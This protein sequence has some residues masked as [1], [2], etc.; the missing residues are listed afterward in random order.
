MRMTDAV[1]HLLIINVL[2]FIASLQYG[3]LLREYLALWFVE[4]PNF[5]YWQPVSSMFMHGSWMHLLFNMYGLWAFGSLLEQRWGSSKFLFFYFSC[6]LGAAALYLGVNYWQYTSGIETLEAAGLNMDTVMDYIMARQPLQAWLPYL[7]E[8]QIWQMVDSFT[9]PALG[10]S[11]AIYGILVAFAFMFSEAR[12]M[13]IFLPVPIKAKYFV[14]LIIAGD[15]FFGITNMR[16]GIAHFAH[17]GGAL[18]GFIM[19]WYWKKNQ[20]N[21]NRWN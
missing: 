4:H 11:G 8:S 9:I 2:L 13:L 5:Q 14:P 7:T 6:G 20:F 12:L 10:A 16:T 19:M 18:I 17:I 1:K 3:D 15:L 21:Q